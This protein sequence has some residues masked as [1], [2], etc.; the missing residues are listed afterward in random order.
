MQAFKRNQVEEAISR[1][2]EPG[3]LKPSAGLRTR[4]KRL[5]ETDRSL[6]QKSGLGTNERREFAF[7]SGE[8]PGSGTEVW[9]SGYEA[10]AVL[11]G[12]LLMAH[13]WPQSFAVTVLRQVRPE[14]EREHS[15]TLS[16]DPK[17]LFDREGIRRKAQ[18]GDFAVDNQDPVL[19]TIVS[20]PGGSSS[21]Q[22][23]PIACRAKRGF[24]E[25]LRFARDVQAESRGAV[26]FFDVVGLAHRLSGARAQTRP[27]NRGRG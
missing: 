24:A 6:D 1:I 10:F 15:M 25:A 4:I 20:Q 8:S 16:Q 11:I 26:T 18:E 22:A 12:L 13:G 27:R 9:F 5:L 23:G 17:W 2:V 3:S 19:L 7:F 14:M 21:D